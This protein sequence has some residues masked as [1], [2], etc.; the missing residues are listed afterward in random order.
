MSTTATAETQAPA[1][2]AAALEAP[3]APHEESRPAGPPAP[4]AAA[5]PVGGFRFFQ[6]VAAIA[7]RELGT[8]F[9]TPIA[10][11]LLAVYTVLSSWFFLRGVAGYQFLQKL[12]AR[13]PEILKQ[14]NFTDQIIAPVLQNGAVVL[15][16]VIPFL[17]MRAIAEEKRQHTFQLLMT[18]PIRSSEIVLG[19]FLAACSVLLVV[20][21]ITLVYPYLLGFLALEGGIEWQ[22]VA[23]G[24]FGLFLFGA[25][26]LS[27]GIFFSSL[28]EN[29]VVAAVVTFGV[30]LFMFVLSWAAETSEGTVKVLVQQISVFEHLG[31]FVRG[32]VRLADVVYF[33][34]L[35]VL[36]LW[37]AWTAIER[38]RWA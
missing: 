38:E 19:K 2:T 12:Y 15:L 22:T 5:R 11:V 18:A 16:F 9:T 20:L 28:T 8:Y 1:E 25:A 32:V 26:F 3:A 31:Q 4:V 29:Q 6:N 23:V 36:G 30:A 37:L 24:Y 35:S 34:S 7:R 21:A 14:L 33:V 10:Y 27:L 17:T 13:Q